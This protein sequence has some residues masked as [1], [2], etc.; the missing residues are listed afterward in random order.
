MANRRRPWDALFRISEWAKTQ[1]AGG[2]LTSVQVA[3]KV[4]HRDGPVGTV[5]RSQQRQRDGVVATE[6]NHSR[7]GFALLRG[8]ELVG[9][10][11]WVACED[12][13]VALFDLV[14]SPC[15]VVP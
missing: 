9:I 2:G 3:V 13:V 14:Q 5:D 6:G 12:I 4:D 10:G 7:Q 8:A 11:G 15:V 1:G